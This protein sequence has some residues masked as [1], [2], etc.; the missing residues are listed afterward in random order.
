MC[1]FG[2]HLAIAQYLAPKMEGH[3][4]DTD[5]DGYTALHWAS[6]E[7]QLSMVEFL[8]R[9]CGFDVKAKNKVGLSVLLSVCIL[10]SF[11][12]PASL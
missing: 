7:G 8:V 1:A 4:F 6:Q 5:D 9:T 10:L 12:V 11:W 3:L 2:G